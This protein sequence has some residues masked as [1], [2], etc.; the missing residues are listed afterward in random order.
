MIAI[1]E[2][3]EGE[4]ERVFTITGSSHAVDKAKQMI[5][6]N[7]KREEERRKMKNQEYKK[8]GREVSFTTFKQK[9]KNFLLILDLCMCILVY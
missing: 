1:S 7:F 8:L 3:I 2:A 4:N 9:N 5:Y 6:Q